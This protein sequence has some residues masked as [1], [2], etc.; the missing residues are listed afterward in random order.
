M[1]VVIYTDSTNDCQK[2]WYE[3]NNIK[4]LPLTYLV[5]DEELVDS[6]ERERIIAFYNKM[7]EGAMP[8]TS[9]VNTEAFVQDWTPHLENGDDIFFTGLSSPLTA[10]T[11]N[12]MSAAE[13]L[14]E[15]FPERKMVVVNSKNVAGGLTDILLR[16]CEWRDAGMSAEEIG[17]KV[18]EISNNYEGWFCIEDMKHLTSGGRLTTNEGVAAPVLNIRQIIHLNHDGKLEPQD[19]VKGNNKAVKLFIE[20]LKE[21]AA[22]PVNDP[23]WISHALSEEFADQLTEA[24]KEEFGNENVIK[25]HFGG[26]VVSHIGPNSTAVFF[27]SK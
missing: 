6:V 5:E 26:V 19:K 20:K 24:I 10:T 13:I 7:L 12:A 22:D 11:N 23:I 3:E 16:A 4:M 2:E 9:A 14:K 15:K 8:K 21:N 27:R 1:S 18:Q 25:K 17:E